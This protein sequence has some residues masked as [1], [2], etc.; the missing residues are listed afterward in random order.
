MV[1]DK[2]NEFKTLLVAVDAL[3]KHDVFVK[4]SPQE[5]TGIFIDGLY[6]TYRLAL[7]VSIS[8]DKL[9]EFQRNTQGKGN[10]LDYA[11]FIIRTLHN[12]NSYSILNYY[13]AQFILTTLKIVREEKLPEIEKL[14]AHLTQLKNYSIVTQ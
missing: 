9:Q 1:I 8:V 4:A 6:E 5:L 11:E 10:V 2:S 12:E 7:D 14:L 3:L 13:T